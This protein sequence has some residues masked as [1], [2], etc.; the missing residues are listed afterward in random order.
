[1]IIKGLI[2]KIES[3]KIEID[4]KMIVNDLYSVDNYSRRSKLVSLSPS[5]KFILY[6]I[7]QRGPLPQKDILEK[8]LLPKRTVAYSLK[9][10]LE[11]RFISQYTGTKDKRIKFYEALI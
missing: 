7:K 8:T 6:I 5:G 4:S 2:F 10:L 11:E 3:K 9:R 1:L